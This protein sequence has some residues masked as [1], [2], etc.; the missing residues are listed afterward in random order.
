MCIN[1]FLNFPSVPVKVS[2]NEYVEISKNYSSPE[3][4]NFINGVANNIFKYLTE[5]NQ[6]KKNDRGMQ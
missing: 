2:I 1:E 4:S 5:N 6:I 3:S